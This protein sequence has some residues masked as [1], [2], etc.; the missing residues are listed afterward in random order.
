MKV[1]NVEQGTKEWLDL[2]S[3]IPTASNFKKLVASKGDRSK[4]L[5]EYA[6]TLAAEKFAGGEIDSFEG[7]AHTERGRL[8]EPEAVESYCFA[9][10]VEA[11]EVGFITNDA[12]TVGCSPDRLIGEDGML[13]IKCLKAENHIKA[14]LYHKK[15]GKSPTDYYQQAQGQMMVAGRKW[16]DLCFYHPTLPMLVVRQTPDIDFTMNLSIR[17]TEVQKLRDEI[18]KVLEEV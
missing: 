8:L 3:G 4:S 11:Q 16:C 13:E 5:D 14:I 1:H 12:G 6:R 17:L 18:I 9:H 7:N 15:H 2:R 10:E